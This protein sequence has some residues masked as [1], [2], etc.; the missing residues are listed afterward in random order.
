VQTLTGRPPASARDWI[1]A[2]ADLFAQ[3]EQALAATAATSKEGS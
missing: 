1:R 2:H 3:P